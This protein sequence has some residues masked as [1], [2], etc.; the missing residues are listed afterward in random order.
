MV[1]SNC[2]ISDV[3]LLVFVE[4]FACSMS[5]ADRLQLA[6]AMDQNKLPDS[7]SIIRF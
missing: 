2:D 3:V 6:S 4:L 7:F 1:L 5:S